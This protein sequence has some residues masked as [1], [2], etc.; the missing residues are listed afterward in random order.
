MHVWPQP[1]QSRLTPIICVCSRQPISLLKIEHIPWRAKCQFPGCNH[2]IV[3]IHGQFWGLVSRS[4]YFVTA[5]WEHRFSRAKVGPSSSPHPVAA[6][7]SHLF[8]DKTVFRAK[9]HIYLEGLLGKHVASP[10]GLDALGE[11]DLL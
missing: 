5:T 6:S 4:N 7:S 8:F 9:A 3:R 1:K 10:I 2:P 11:L